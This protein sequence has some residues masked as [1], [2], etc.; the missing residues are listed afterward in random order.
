MKNGVKNDPWLKLIIVSLGGII[1]SLALLWSLQQ[2]SI[3]NS[4]NGMYM[5]GGMNNQGMHHN[6]NM[7]MDNGRM[8]GNM[9]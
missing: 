8:M 5:Q 2:Y 9:Q 6:M 3:F 4:Y 1:I 7:Q